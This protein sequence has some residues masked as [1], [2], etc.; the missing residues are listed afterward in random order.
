[1]PTEDLTSDLNSETDFNTNLNA[2]NASFGSSVRPHLPHHKVNGNNINSSDRGSMQIDLNGNSNK[3][4]NNSSLEDEIKTPDFDADYAFQVKNKNTLKNK[5]KLFFFCC[6]LAI[7]SLCA[8]F[9]DDNHFGLYFF[10][11]SNSLLKL[12]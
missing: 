1:M 5:I 4:S 6:Y 10:N 3:K 2:Q 12:I 9:N 8:Y 7:Y 11:V